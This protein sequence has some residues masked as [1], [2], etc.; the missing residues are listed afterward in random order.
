M[1]TTHKNHAKLK[2]KEAQRGYFR[3]TQGLLGHF[4]GSKRLFTREI[5]CQEL[6]PGP[7]RVKTGS[8]KPEWALNKAPRPHYK[9]VDRS[10]GLFSG[11][12]SNFGPLSK[13]LKGQSDS[14]QRGT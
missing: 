5:G 6:I 8:Q 9:G 2:G 1:P 14:I 10:R 4:R 13:G 11:I 7:K 12:N 3:L